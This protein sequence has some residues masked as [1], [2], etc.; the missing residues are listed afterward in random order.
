MRGD[1][2]TLCPVAYSVLSASIWVRDY[3]LEFLLA[4]F[5]L[6][7]F[8]ESLI[9]FAVGAPLLPALRIRSPDPSSIRLR[10]MWILYQ[11]P[12]FILQ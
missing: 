6:D 9:A 4:H 12:F 5:F 2:V 10:F 7:V 8:C 3:L 11:S 1:R